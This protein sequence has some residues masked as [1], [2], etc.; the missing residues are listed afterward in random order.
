MRSATT[1]YLKALRQAQG[2]A[3]YGLAVMAHTSPT[4][5]IAIERHGLRPS[6]PVRQRIAEALGVPEAEIW[7][8]QSPQE[9][10]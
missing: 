7:P 5:I 4:T 2:L 9:A 1:N 6:D 3:Q 8:A 10:A